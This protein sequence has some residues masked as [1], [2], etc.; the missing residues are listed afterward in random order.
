MALAIPAH[1]ITWLFLGDSITHGL[2]HTQGARSFVE[3]VN[4]TVR[5]DE[6]RITDVLV[7]T[8]VSGWQ[9]GDLLGAWDFHAARFSPDVAIVMLGTN[10][11]KNG[12][13]GV[14][15]Y[16]EGLVE[17]VRRL[18][19]GGAQVVLMVPP[20]IREEPSARVGFSLYCEAVRDV[21]A[22][23]GLPLVDHPA[24]WA[25]NAPGGDVDVWLNDDIHPNAA[26]HRRMA[27]AILDVIWR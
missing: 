5:G 1:P 4:E 9:V 2:V 24:D 14:P 16:R 21:A 10:D 12:P 6:G 19:G 17:I 25:D 15:A 26:G 13:D 18:R 20:P 22:E 3:H 8:A 11:A 27:D 23:T 7:N